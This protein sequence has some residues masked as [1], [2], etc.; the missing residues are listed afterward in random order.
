MKNN[1]N[2]SSSNSEIKSEESYEQDSFLSEDINNNKEY[3]TF[4]LES[5]KLKKIEQKRKLLKKQ[6]QDLLK[7]KEIIERK[8][9]ERHKLNDLI[10]SE[11]LNNKNSD[12]QSKIILRDISKSDNNDV[13]IFKDKDLDTQVPLNLFN[14][15]EMKILEEFRKFIIRKISKKYNKEV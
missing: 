13:L 14:H 15:E 11:Q 1:N 8:K 7:V 2:S 3:K 12:Y 10:H 9:N 6:K 5:E 4:F